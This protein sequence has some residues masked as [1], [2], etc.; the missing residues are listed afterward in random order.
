MPRQSGAHYS[1]KGAARIPR[2]LRIHRN[3]SRQIIPG[4]ADPHSRVYQQVPLEAF[5]KAA[6]AAGRNPDKDLVGAGSSFLQV[7]DFKV[8]VTREQQGLHV[9]V[10]VRSWSL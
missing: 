2:K 1:R 7:G 4:C 9:V 3:P 5:G 8:T 6:N 10:V